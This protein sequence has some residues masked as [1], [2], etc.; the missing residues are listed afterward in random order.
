ME[1]LR[2]QELLETEVKTLLAARWRTVPGVRCRYYLM[3]ELITSE[4]CREKTPKNASRGQMRKRIETNATLRF[5]LHLTRKR[6]F[7]NEY[8]LIEDHVYLR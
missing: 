6:N 2:L 1:K 7:E 8:T 5:T 4:F 3:S